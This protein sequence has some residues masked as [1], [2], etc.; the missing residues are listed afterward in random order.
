VTA[1]ALPPPSLVGVLA[2]AVAGGN[3]IPLPTATPALTIDT[4]AIEKATRRYIAAARLHNREGRK[5]THTARA[6]AWW[7]LVGSIEAA[8]PALDVFDAVYAANRIRVHVHA[9]LDDTVGSQEK[10]LIERCQCHNT[11]APPCGH[12]TS[13]TD[14]VACVRA[15]ID[16]SDAA[17]WAAAA[18][19]T[20]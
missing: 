18:G 15:P 8:N 7:A 14:A 13:C 19:V 3:L 17:D 10:H 1:D 4:P 2:Q 16:T 12:C 11:T 20:P 9:T 5:D 6:I